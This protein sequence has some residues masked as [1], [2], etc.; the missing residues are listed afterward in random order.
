MSIVTRDRIGHVYVIESSDGASVKIGRSKNPS[1]RIRGIKTQGSV[2]GRHWVSPLQMDCYELERACHLRYSTHRTIGEWFSLRFEEAVSGVI[3]LMGEPPSDLDVDRVRD[4]LAIA[5][6][7][8]SDAL[9]DALKIRKEAQA[10]DVHDMAL[11]FIFNEEEIVFSNNFIFDEEA[12]MRRFDALPANVANLVNQYTPLYLILIKAG[13]IPEERKEVLKQ[14]AMD[15]RL[16][17][18][19]QLTEA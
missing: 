2:T 13:V 9:F 10:P 4:E 3:G 7:A 16:A 15:W 5:K 12:F 1:R 18:A 8:A 17:H 6:R 11:A 14:H 19:P